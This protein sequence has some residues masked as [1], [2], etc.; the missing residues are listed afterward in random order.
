MLAG[1]CAGIVDGA[2]ELLIG[3]DWGVLGIPWGF[4]TFIPQLAVSVRRLHD[5][6][7]SGWWLLLFFIPFGGGVV[8]IVWFCFPGTHSYNRFGA[9]P[10]PL[11]PGP[12]HRER[13]Q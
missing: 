5:T 13:G 7:R 4:A 10:L 3:C 6:D 2:I 12:P 9:N 1:K 11:P 8:L